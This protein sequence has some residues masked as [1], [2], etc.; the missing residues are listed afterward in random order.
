MTARDAF[1]IGA[2]VVVVVAAILGGAFFPGPRIVVGLSLALVLGCAAVLSWDRLRIEEGL[3]VSWIGW[4]VVSAAASRAA[5]LA[6]RETITVWIVTCALWFVARRLTVRVSRA[7]LVT[8]A[9][10][11]AIVA[12]GV[13]CEALGMGGIRV[14]G[15]LENPNVAASLLVVS[16]PLLGALGGRKGWLLGGAVIIALGLVLTGSR[17]GLLALLASA[18]LFLPRGRTRFIGLLLGGLA[19][20]VVLM[21]RFANQP[22]VLAWFRP[23]IWSAVL[24]LWAAHPLLGVGPGGLVDAAG[25]ERLLHADHIGQRQF[26]ISYAESSP[27]ALLVQTGLVGVLIIGLAV[28]FWWRRARSGRPMSNPFA[29]TLAAMAVMGMFH[30]LLTVDIVLWW[31]ALSLGLLEAREQPVSS[32]SSRVAQWRPARVVVGLVFVFVVLWGVVQPAWA[33]WLWRSEAPDTALATRVL[34]AE[35][36]FDAPLEWRVRDLLKEEQWSWSTAAEAV[37]LGR[38]SVR[39]HPGAATLWS[40][41]GMTHAR[42]V[43]DFGPWPDSVDGGRAA[44][45]RAVELEPYVPWSWLEW[46]R[47]ERNL[48]HTATAVDLVTKAL[49]AEPNTVRARLFL[50][51]LE[52]DRGDHEAARE[53]YTS[54]LQTL[55]YRKLNG[56]SGYERELLGAPAWQFREIEKALQ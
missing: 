2:C 32:D 17:A 28:C 42:V 19:V 53:A 33:R 24:R 12:L 23:A 40:V 30:D 10:G 37:S 3:V 20:S 16:L 41:L 21:W 35:P 51:R 26:L 9:A 7:G 45:A 44:F 14:G 56:L 25:A 55:R 52:L 49:E 48:G 18:A 4:G 50:A 15:L 11:A 27:L 1:G 43:A 36:W 47:L 8:L 39:V 54:A 13:V 29:A 6:A 38:R 34:R 31:W 5:P 22:D 46:A